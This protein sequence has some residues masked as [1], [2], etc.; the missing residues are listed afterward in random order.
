MCGSN[1][2]TASVTSPVRGYVGDDG[3]D[4]GPSRDV[5]RSS[6]GVVP[7]LPLLSLR[8]VSMVMPGMPPNTL[9]KSFRPGRLY[10]RVYPPRTTSSL[11]ISAPSSPSFCD[12]VHAKPMFGAMLFL[13][14][15]YAYVPDVY[16]LNVGV[17]P[18]CTPG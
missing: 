3:N 5:S 6:S 8:L 10:E 9:V 15:R 4:G 7:R 13:S 1:T 16:C 18:G 17:T 14:T 11:P 12:G 2:R